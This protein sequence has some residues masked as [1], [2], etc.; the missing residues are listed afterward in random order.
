MRARVGD[1]SGN[2]VVD[3]NFVP[4]DRPILRIDGGNSFCS[5]HFDPDTLDNG[6]I[7]E[8]RQVFYELAKTRIPDGYTGKR[9][10]GR[11]AF[12][13]A[14]YPARTPSVVYRGGLPVCCDQ[15]AAAFDY[16]FDYGFDS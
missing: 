13:A 16:G 10:C 7:G 4:D 12:W 9:H 1:D 3:W 11:D 6:A 5:S 8:V 15:D 2:F 14:G